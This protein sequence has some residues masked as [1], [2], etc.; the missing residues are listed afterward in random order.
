MSLVCQYVDRDVL[1]K[2]PEKISIIF[3]LLFLVINMANRAQFLTIQQQVMPSF[4]PFRSSTNDVV[5][6][7]RDREISA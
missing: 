4:D 2:A 6:Q 1:R 5:R 7:A 3:R